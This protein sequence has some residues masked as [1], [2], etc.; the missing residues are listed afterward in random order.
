MLLARLGSAFADAAA[1]AA[2]APAV[3]SSTL[4]LSTTTLP[5]ALRGSMSYGN[6]PSTETLCSSSS[7]VRTSSKTVRPRVAPKRSRRPSKNAAP[8]ASSPPPWPRNC[9]SRALVA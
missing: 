2:L 9:A 7:N 4:P 3:S 8:R 1:L 5:G 6:R